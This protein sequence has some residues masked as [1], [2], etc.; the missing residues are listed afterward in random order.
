MSGSRYVTPNQFAVSAAG[1][2]LAGALLYFYETGTNTPQNTYQDAALTIANANPIVADSAGQFGSVFLLSSPNYRV[3]LT[4]ASGTQ[5][6]TMDPVGPGVGSS[7]TGSVPIG[8]MVPFGGAEASVP[9]GYL[10][11]GGQ[12]VSRTTYAALFAV[13]GTA[14]GVGDGATTFNVPDKRGRVSIGKDDMNGVAANRITAGVSGISGVTLGAAGGAQALQ[15]HSHTIS[16]PGHTHAVTDPGHVHN[17]GAAHDTDVLIY[18]GAGGNSN[19]TGGTAVLGET[20]NSATTGLTV[21]SGTTGITAT[22][23]FGAGAAQN[24][25]PGQIDNWI[26]RAS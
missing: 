19:I 20:M 14:Y 10:I 7:G 17:F 6:W 3:T 23:S 18:K 24:V 8:A 21:D 25:Q 12:A 1:V 16:D 13:I 11:C 2:P 5:I 9:A 4:D 15:S 26:I 22:A